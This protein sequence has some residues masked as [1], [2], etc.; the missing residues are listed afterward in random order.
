MLKLRNVHAQYPLPFKIVP[1]QLFIALS[2]QTEFI[3]FLQFVLLLL[4]LN[5]FQT[6][7]NSDCFVSFCS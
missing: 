6:T 7:L 5:I 4:P 2:V 1:I 3:V